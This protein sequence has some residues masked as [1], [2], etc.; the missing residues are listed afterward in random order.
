MKQYT[1]ARL[2][3]IAIERLEKAALLSII[4]E[5]QSSKCFNHNRDGVGK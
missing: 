1:H 3:F 4:K 2:A 5:A